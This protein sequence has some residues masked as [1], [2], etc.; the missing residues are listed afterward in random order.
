MFLQNCRCIAMFSEVLETCILDMDQS[1]HILRTKICPVH[2][3][4]LPSLGPA[5]FGQNLALLSLGA[6]KQLQ[7]NQTNFPTSYN[8]C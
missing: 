2:A 3:L 7:S 1:F 8:L 5:T 6:S 4:L